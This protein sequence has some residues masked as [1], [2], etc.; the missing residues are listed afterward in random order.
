[1]LTAALLIVAALALSALALTFVVARRAL[2]VFVRVALVA[3][4]ALALLVGYVFWRW[5]SSITTRPPAGQRPRPAT[6][7]RR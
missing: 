7:A 6:P 2:R 1:M 4:V 3:L 5:Q